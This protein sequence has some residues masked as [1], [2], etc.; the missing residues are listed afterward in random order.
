V[1]VVVRTVTMLWWLLDLVVELLADQRVQ[2]LFTIDAGSA[3]EDG[4][5]QAIAQSGGRL[6]PWQQAVATR[7]DLAISASHRGELEQLQC[8][9][10]ITSHGPGFNKPISVPSNGRPP[11]PSGGTG[12]ATTVV[13]SHESQ[14]AQWSEGPCHRTV[15]AGDPCFDALRASLPDRERYRH[16]LGVRPQ[17]RLVVISS[18]WGPGSLLSA[19]PDLLGNLLS[20]L[21]VD[22]YVVAAIL[23]ANVWVGHGPWQVR[24]WLRRAL[25]AGL[26]L[27]PHREGWRAT[28]VAADSVI[29]D[30]GSVTFYAATLGV[31][32]LLGAFAVHDVV[33]GTA[34]AE[35]GKRAPRWSHQA[36]VR[37]QLDK[38]GYAHDPSR[39]GDLVD[40]SYAAA[41]GSLERLRTVTYELIRLE[42]PPLSARV[43]AVAEPRPETRAVTAH[44]VVA[45][46]DDTSA[47]TRVRLERFPAAL[48]PE[49]TASAPGRHLAVDAAEPDHR[50]RQSAAVLVRSPSPACDEDPVAWAR[51]LLDAYP[52]CRVAAAHVGPG[53]IVVALRDGPTLNPTID[54]R[55][56]ASVAASGVYACLIAGRLG[57]D[58]TRQDIELVTGGIRSR[59]QLNRLAARDA[60]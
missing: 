60:R 28:V 39:Y 20:Q 46:V 44:L 11:I 17:Q 4:V 35:F 23:H 2:V 9:L 33:A 45:T 40:R 59:L 29:G 55:L 7:F 32:T 13:L 42:P 12:D 21:P 22:E 49:Y 54:A 38:A 58:E 31:P 6:V 24:L 14:R 8:P 50:L 26:R 27:V 52:G 10:L 36:P 30:H 48:E 47:S 16:A 1:L 25:E 34:M 43:L 19:A 3:Y 37:E 57:P 5:A 53:S 18:T 41:G 15:V 51:S 56:S